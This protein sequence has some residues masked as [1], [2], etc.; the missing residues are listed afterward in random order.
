MKIAV[1]GVVG[2][3]KTTVS[4]ILAEKFNLKR[5]YV[6]GLMREMAK[7]RGVTFDELTVIAKDSSVDLELDKR[8]IEAGKEDD[9]VVDGRLSFYFV[10]DAF[11]IY[12]KV[13]IEEAARRIFAMSR[14]DQR[15]DNFEDCLEACEMRV[16]AEKIRY[17]KFYGINFGDESDF[18]LVV[19]TTDKSVAEVVKIILEKLDK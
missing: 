11:K 17:K 12:L 2:A 10:P 1:S 7:E 15:Y 5:I 8:Q 14:E 6:G 13:N 19:D 3:G 16:E 4:K 9:I 18:D